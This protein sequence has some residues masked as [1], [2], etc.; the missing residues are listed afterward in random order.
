MV[1]IVEQALLDRDSPNL[2]S[3]AYDSFTRHLL[4]RDLRAT[5]C[6]LRAGGR[7]HV[8]R[9]EVADADG[10]AVAEGLATVV[11]A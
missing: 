9:V 3:R 6:V 11:L 8:V 4:A 2:R 7:R 10:N 5:P 1:A